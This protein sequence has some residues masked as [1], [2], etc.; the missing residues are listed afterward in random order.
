MRCPKL[1]CS[2]SFVGI[3][4]LERDLICRIPDSE[5]EL[6]IHFGCTAKC[7]SMEFNSCWSERMPGRMGTAA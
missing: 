4:I 1:M 6:P 5:T 7:V 3:P 2:S